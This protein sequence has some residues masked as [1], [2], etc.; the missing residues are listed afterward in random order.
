L[1]RAR[2]FFIRYFTGVI[3]PKQKILSMGFAG[4]VEAVGSAV[5]EFAVGGHVFGVKGSGANA[6]CVRVRESAPMSRG[7]RVDTTG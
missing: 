3:R 7:R 1:R 5:T 6:E 4:E 2:P